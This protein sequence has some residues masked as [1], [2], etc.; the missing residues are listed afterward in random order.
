[1]KRS[2]TKRKKNTKRNEIYKTDRD[3]VTKTKEV[4]VQ[5]KKIHTL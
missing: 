5:L 3:T 1:M 4:R 2:K